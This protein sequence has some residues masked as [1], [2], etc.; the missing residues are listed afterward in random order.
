MSALRGVSERRVSLEGIIS[1]TALPGR[2]YE[3]CMVVRK[4]GTT[5]NGLT[6]QIKPDGETKVSRRA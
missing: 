4:S 1:E 3:G 6:P 2:T 5:A